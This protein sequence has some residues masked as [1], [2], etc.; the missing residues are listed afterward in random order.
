MVRGRGGRRRIVHEEV[1]YEG[2]KESRPKY[3]VCYTTLDGRRMKGT[4]DLV[5][6]PVKAPEP[7]FPG[8]S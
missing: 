6:G 8:L 4:L 3:P 1:I 5:V 2:Y 7:E